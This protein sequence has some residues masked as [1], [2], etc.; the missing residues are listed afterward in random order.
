MVKRFLNF[1]HNLF[2]PGKSFKF[3]HI[4]FQRFL[5][6]TQNFLK[7]LSNY[8][9]FFPKTTKDGTE[10]LSLH[11]IHVY[12]ASN[13]KKKKPVYSVVHYLSKKRT[14]NTVPQTEAE[15]QLVFLT[16]V[17]PTLQN[18]SSCKWYVNED[19]ARVD[20]SQL[21]SNSVVKARTDWWWTSSI[22][23]PTLPTLNFF[24]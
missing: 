13:Q 20:N 24:F 4:L 15:I 21:F 12:N 17:V 7:F 9:T 2:I 1:I 8:T 11:T 19:V 16:W 18:M 10:L 23:F 22:I 3:L 6:F 14:T 5:D